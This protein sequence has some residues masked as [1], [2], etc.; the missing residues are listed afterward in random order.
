MFK[1]LFGKKN[2]GFYLQLDDNTPTPTAAA[3]AQPSTVNVSAPVAAATATPAPSSTAVAETDPKLAT[4]AQKAAEKAAAKAAAK[5][6][7]AEQKSKTAPALAPTAPVPAAPVFSNFATEY[8][9]APS[10]DSSR[11]R[12]GAN[13]SAFLDL[14]RQ[15]QKPASAKK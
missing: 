1:K 15:V 10:S 4:A 6:T 5:A 14:A 8:L 3:K 9:I 7:K 11:R 13:M 12:P 2:D